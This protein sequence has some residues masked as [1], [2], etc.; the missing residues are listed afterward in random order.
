MTVLDREVEFK[1]VLM[2]I[3]RKTIHKEIPLKEGY[4]YADYEDSMY[5]DWCNLHLDTNMFENKEQAHDKLNQMLQE[6]KDFF[7]KNFL[8]VQDSS[9]KLVASAGLWKGKDFPGDRLRLHYVSVAQSAQHNRIAQ[10]MITKLCMMYDAIP[11]KYPLYL[12]TQSQSYGAIA[13]YSKLGFTPYLGEYNGCSDKENEEAWQFTTD[14]MREKA[15][16]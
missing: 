2:V 10:A 9:G 3:A 5:E 15:T 12:A 11:G 8:F 1:K 13:L 4:S 16:R 6:D 14:V 7:K